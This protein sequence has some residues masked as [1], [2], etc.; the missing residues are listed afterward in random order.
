MSS[1]AITWARVPVFSYM[2][3]PVSV[4][5]PTYSAS[6]ISCVGSTLNPRMR[7]HTISAVQEVH[8]VAL[9]PLPRVAVDVAAVQEDRRTLLDVVR[10]LALHPVEVEEAVLVG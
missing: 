4:T 1:A 9:D 6:A 10:R 7:S 3:L 2:N 5:R 8:A